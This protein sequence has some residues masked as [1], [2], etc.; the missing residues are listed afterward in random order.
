MMEPVLLLGTVMGVFFNA[1]SPGWLIT[2]LLVMTL[3]WTTWRTTLKTFETYEK[4]IKIEREEEEQ[5]LLPAGSKDTKTQHISYNPR[6][7]PPGLREIYEEESR[8][9][10]TKIGFLCV[11]WIIIAFFSILKGGE[12]GSGIV[13]C[14]TLAYWGLVLAPVPLIVGMVWK[15]GNDLAHMHEEKERLGFEFVEG[16]LLWTRRNVRIYPLYT[17]TAGFAAGALGIAAGTILGP[18]LLEMGMVPLVG[19]AS[20]GFMVIFTASSTSFQFLVMGQLQIDYAGFFCCIGFVGG[21][22]GNTG[23]GALVKKYKK[24]WFIVAILS[25]ILAASTLLMGYA[26]YERAAIG[27]EHGVSQ[28]IRPL[29]PMKLHPNLAASVSQ[30]KQWGPSYHAQGETNESPL[31]HALQTSVASGRA[32]VGK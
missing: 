10:F 18:I 6:L 26:G 12:G 9:N 5:R 30:A 7:A 17:I 28:G 3:T 11:A 4:E 22:I 23:V 1:V 8:W 25:V 15:M 31:V 19:T 13:D 16:D 20:S 14:G 27:L 21:A 24:T 32:A 29:C 2:V